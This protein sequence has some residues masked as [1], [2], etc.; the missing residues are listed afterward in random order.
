MIVALCGAAGDPQDLAAQRARLE[1]AGATVTR[2]N[3][4]AARLAVEAAHA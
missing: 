2:S 4:H 3:A 1:Q